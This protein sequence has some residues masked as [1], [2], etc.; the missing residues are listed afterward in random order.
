MRAPA[1]W[2]QTKRHPAAAILGPAA[3]LYGAFTGRRMMLEGLE[4]PVPVLCI[5][6]FVVGGAGKTPAALALGKK[7]IAAGKNIYFLTRGYRSA[8]EHR[9]PQRV[10][11]ARHRAEEVGDE[12]LLLARVAPTIVSADRV[13]A[14]QLALNE[15]AE[16]L[17]AD[18]G[19]QNPSLHYGLRLAVVDGETGAGNG[20]CLPAGPLRAPLAVQLDLIDAVVVAGDGE[21]GMAIAEQAR[22]LDK[23]VGHAALFVDEAIAKKL[24]GQKVYAFAGIARPSKFYA[25]LSA[26]GAEIVG[27]QSFP[28]H[29]PYRPSEIGHLQRSAQRQDAMLITTEKDFMRFA[30]R[31]DVFDPQLPSPLAVPVALRFSDES[32]LDTL[33]SRVI[34]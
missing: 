22:A 25:T 21:P 2:W 11:R 30:G 13:A 26:L 16:I 14:A 15:G 6:N 5:G 24:A 10:D 17:I 3:T 19:L 18:D 29:H 20:F 12:A 8:A 31:N 7:L 1:F 32:F 27:T 34:A 23:P 28:D 9:P 33:V 4:L